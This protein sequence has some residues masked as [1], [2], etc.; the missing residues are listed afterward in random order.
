MRQQSGFTLIEVLI[1]VVVLAGGLLGLAA[2]QATALGN[3]KSAYNRSQATQLAYDIADRM[4]ANPTAASKYLTSF[5]QPSAAD[6]ATGDNPCTAC[7][8][9]AN[10][11]TAD[12]MAEQDLYDWYRNLTDDLTGGNGTIA[13]DAGANVYTVSVSWDDDKD[14]AT[15]DLTL[16][17]RFGL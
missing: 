6:C 1:A 7:K 8:S 2:I 12:Q 5:M 13:K 14:P 15:A 4:R 17:V 11:C 10:A 9:S 16:V 3:N